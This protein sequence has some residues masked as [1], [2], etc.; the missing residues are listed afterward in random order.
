GLQ[1]KTKV[2]F[3]CDEANTLGKMDQIITALTVGRGF[4]VNMQLYYQDF[5]EVK[6]CWPDGSDQ[7]LLANVSQAFFAV[8]DYAT[9]EYVSNRLGEETIVVASG[10]TSGGTSSQQGDQGNRSTTHSRNWNENWQQHGRKLLKPEE[11]MGL[12]ARIAITFTPG[13]PP[14]W[15]R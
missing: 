15:S 7:T 2:H 3:I 5:G 6:R 8:N 1:E 13:V 12:P 4:G 10:G 14:I 9:A 11:V